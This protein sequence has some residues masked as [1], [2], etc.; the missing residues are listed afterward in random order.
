MENRRLQDTKV[1]FFFFFFFF[2]CFFFLLSLVMY[3]GHT[4]TNY[5][6]VTCKFNP[7][8]IKIQ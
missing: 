4:F 1:G 5:Q 3:V 6:T 8:Y 7:N 2:V